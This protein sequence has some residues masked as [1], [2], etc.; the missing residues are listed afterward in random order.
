L[1][2]NPIHALVIS[3]SLGA[4][5][6]LVRQ[7]EYEKKHPGAEC[8]A[9]LRTFTAWALLGC[10]AGLLELAG[11]AWVFA[12]GLAVFT[13]VLGAIHL[14]NRP[15]IHVGLTTFS[16]GVLTYVAGGLAAYGKFVAAA[17]LSVGAMLILG[18]KEWSHAWTKRMTS[19]DLRYLLQFA[20]FSGLVL[21]LVP[22][23]DIG[24]YKAFNPHTIWLM[25]V[26]VAGLGFAG[27]VAVRWLGARA[28][29]LLTGLA[30]GL[31]SSTVTTMAF[32][33][34]SVKS[35]SLSSSLALGAVLASAIMAPRGLIMVAVIDPDVALPLL[36][37]FAL[38]SLPGLLWVGWEILRRRAHHQKHEVNPPVVGNPLSPAMALKFGL[39]YA[40]ISFI[41]KIA[42]QKLPPEWL[43]GVSFVS[44]L[45]DI[46]AITVSSAQAASAN[47]LDPLVAARCVLLGSLANTGLKAVL[48]G[49]CGSP[50][51][52]RTTALILAAS[53]AFGAMGWWWMG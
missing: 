30:G 40:G 47:T 43:Y 32:G 26:L 10:G 11:A 34:Q 19:E 36:I 20:A 24:P 45:T 46:N 8:P 49:T 50:L 23:E 52:M 33:R 16:I 22:D 35:P 6:G 4:L 53:A 41:V 27:Y 7:W 15:K 48:A 2:S 9:G 42:A 3:A 38:I 39:L 12:V 17:S 28:G 1:Q 14:R 44:G 25:V 51:Y 5:I 29:I 37:P 18:S 31:A 21:P 13:I